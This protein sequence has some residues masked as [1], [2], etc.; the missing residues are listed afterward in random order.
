MTPSAW[1]EE[2]DD[3]DAHLTSP[4]PLLCFAH[5]P[6]LG[7]RHPVDACLAARDQHVGHLLAGR[8][9]RRNRAGGPVLEVVG[10]GDHGQGPLPVVR[11][12]QQLVD[13]S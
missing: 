13:H 6:G 10:M 8:G 12:R 9:P 4:G 3:V 1:S 5:W 7:R 11:E 2:L